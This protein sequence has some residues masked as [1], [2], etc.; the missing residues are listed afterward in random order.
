MKHK[1]LSFILIGL[2]VLILTGT[3]RADVCDDL[4]LAYQICTDNRDFQDNT[5]DYVTCKAYDNKYDCEYNGCIWW[6]IKN[7]CQA[8]ICHTDSNFSGIPN[9]S[10]FIMWK[11]ETG[12]ICPKQSCNDTKCERTGKCCCEVYDQGY[13]YCFC[14]ADMDCDMYN[15]TCVES[16]ISQDEPD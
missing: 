13:K 5:V 14:C 6:S 11:H 8:S 7:K 15:G 9:I 10:E 1:G 12:R 2:S 3:G 16:C 4:L